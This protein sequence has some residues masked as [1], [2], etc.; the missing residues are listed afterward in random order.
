MRHDKKKSVIR[1]AAICAPANAVMLISPTYLAEKE[2]EIS[3]S[4]ISPIILFVAGRYPRLSKAKITRIYKNCFKSE[5]LYKFCHLKGC[6][7]KNRDKNIIFKYNQIKIKKVMGTFCNFR[8]IIDIRLDRFL[9][10]AIVIVDFFEVAFLSL[11][12]F[13]FIFYS[14]VCHFSQIYEWQHAVFS[15]AINYHTEITIG[16]HINVK[17]WVLLSYQVN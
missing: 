12:E 7:N 14:K 17:N 4:K 16:I 3:L 10:Y 6:K 15:F 11:F 9:N 5:N 13:F 8:N 1:I 2:E